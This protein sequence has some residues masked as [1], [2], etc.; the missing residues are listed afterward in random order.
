MLEPG[1]VRVG[2]RR[3]APDIPTVLILCKGFRSPALEAEGRIGQHAVEAPDGS[4]RKELRVCQRVLPQ[5]TELLC[6]M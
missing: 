3:A 5:D 4:G 2:I 6:T 1:K